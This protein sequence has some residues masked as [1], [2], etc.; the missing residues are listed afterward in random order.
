MENDPNAG[1]YTV[2]NVSFQVRSKLVG[3]APRQVFLASR[4]LS[5]FERMGLESSGSQRDDYAQF[6]RTVCH[7]WGKFGKEFYWHIK[8]CTM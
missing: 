6:Y 7:L 8:S 4:Q 2:A 1:A 5:P 3:G